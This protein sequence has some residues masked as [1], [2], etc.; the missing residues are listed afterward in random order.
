MSQRGILE[1]CLG[2]L[3]LGEVSRRDI[4]VKHLG[5]AFWRG[6]LERY[7]FERCLRELSLAEV[8]W[9][10]ILVKYLGEASGKGAI[11]IL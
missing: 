9:R 5:K 2:E 11:Q 4:L 1:R 8:S 6:V 10:D 3:S 7:L